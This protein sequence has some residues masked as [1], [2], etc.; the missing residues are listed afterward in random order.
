ML[1]FVKNLYNLSDNLLAYSKSIVHQLSEAIFLLQ[2][3]FTP[4]FQQFPL[5]FCKL[6]LPHL[7]FVKQLWQQLS[8]LQLPTQEILL[9]HQLVF[10]L[11]FLM[12]Q[13]LDL[14][15]ELVDK[16]FFKAVVEAELVVHAFRN[17][18]DRCIFRHF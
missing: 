9:G 10:P 5:P 13:V 2:F 12:L 4:I 11:R 6:Q 14:E 16:L 15:E 7:L 18:L 3:V 17:D 1:P 8:S